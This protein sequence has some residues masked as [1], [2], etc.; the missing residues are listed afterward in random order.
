MRQIQNAAR[1][2]PGHVQKIGW[3]FLFM[4]VSIGSNVV[5]SSLSLPSLLSLYPSDL[6]RAD[7]NN[8]GAIYAKGLAHY[9][10]VML[11]VCCVHA[12]YMCIIIM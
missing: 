2:G 10:Q 9:Y 3:V 7:I 8:C 11:H 12:I 6:L 1:W 5:S 4:P